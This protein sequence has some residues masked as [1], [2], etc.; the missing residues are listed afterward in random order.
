MGERC[1][2]TCR[3][4]NVHDTGERIGDC[5]HESECGTGERGHRAYQSHV[6]G[7]GTVFVDSFGREETKPQHSCVFWETGEFQPDQEQEG[8]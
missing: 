1:C 5:M 8:R 4:W 2:K 7:I 3:W 6:P